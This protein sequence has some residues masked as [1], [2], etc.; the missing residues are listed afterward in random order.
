MLIDVFPL[1]GLRVTTPRLVL[2]LPSQDEL[3]DLAE[4]A[5]R[6]V[7]DPAFMP[8][9]VPWTDHP[10]EQVALN[11]VQHSWAKLAEWS[12]QHWSIGFGVFLDGVI[13]GQQSVDARDFAVTREVGTGSWIGQAHQGRGIGAEMR[14]AVLH[15][16]F[17]GIGARH[18]RSSAAEGNEASLRISRRLGYEADGVQRSALRGELRVEQR[19]RLT[20][21][22]WET[23][24][25]VPVEIEGLAPCLPM[26]GVGAA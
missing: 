12:P 2:R 15:F 24:R 23:H 18:A 10:P 17:A 20:R 11:V 26:L 3:G 1:F 16:A 22:S 5:A 21:E 8:F 14:E 4:L 13:V 9:S 6:G 25:S 19:L 7:H